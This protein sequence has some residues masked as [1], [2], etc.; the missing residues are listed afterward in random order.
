MSAFG[1][2]TRRLGAGFGVGVAAFSAA[3]FGFGTTF[4]RLAYEGGS[5]AL[6][7]VV[8]RTAAFVVIVGVALAVLGRLSWLSLR[9]AFG[10]LWMAVT[11][12]M[13]SLGY[14]GSVAFIP[15]SLAALLFYGYPLLVGVIAVLARRDRMT[16]G[17]AAALVAAFVGLAL[18]LS[19]GFG[20]LD[21]RGIALVL[22]A[23]SGMALTLAFG[24][25]AIENQDALLMSLYT[26]VWML[27][28]LVIAMAVAG[29]PA[30]PATQSGWLGATGLC[31]SYVV[32][33]AGWYTALGLVRPVR[34]AAIY[35]IEP[36]VTL[37]V[38]WLVLDERMS[39]LQWLGAGLVLASVVSMT[40]SRSPR[41]GSDN[42]EGS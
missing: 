21:W 15:V 27:A 16:V 23:A 12:T 20:A 36:L 29:G 1:V 32:A 31:L 4:A 42:P 6:T 9:G 14:Q 33:Y 11:L 19:P 39:A 37:I 13:V 5:D 34:L 28:A 10:T 7:V 24:G 3:T 8:F 25:A 30:F 26:N 41:V 2:L 35:N 18:A 40:V 17:K 22:I 38:A